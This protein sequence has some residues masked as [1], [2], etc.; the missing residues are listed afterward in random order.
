MVYLTIILIATILLPLLAVYMVM[1]VMAVTMEQRR[2][3]SRFR[4]HEEE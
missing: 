1:D 2:V 3:E 4:A